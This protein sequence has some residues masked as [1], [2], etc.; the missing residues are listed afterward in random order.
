M[1]LSLAE[2]NE[3]LREEVRQLKQAISVSTVPAHRHP[4]GIRSSHLQKMFNLLYRHETL[5][6]DIFFSS[7][8][9]DL[10]ES[11]QPCEK[12]A[13][14]MMC[15][16]RKHCREHDIVIETVRNIGWRMTPESKAKVKEG[17]EG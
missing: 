6:R 16:L 7:V 1:Q 15:H 10:P 5:T 9:G 17:L 12:I 3:M 11:D 13:D 2:E 8:Y 14:V 4:L